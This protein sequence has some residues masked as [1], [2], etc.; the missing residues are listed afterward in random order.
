MFIVECIRGE[1]I[2]IFNRLLYSCIGMLPLKTHFYLNLVVRNEKASPLQPRQL[3][4]E[5]ELSSML[6]YCESFL[7]LARCE[8][9]PTPVVVASALFFLSLSPTPPPPSLL[10]PP[11]PPPP[12][13]SSVPPRCPPP[14]SQSPSSLHLQSACVVSAAGRCGRADLASVGV[15][16]RVCGRWRLL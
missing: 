5:H 1:K 10:P 4:R 7:T 11:L 2:S 16:V 14:F 15:L 3:S 6:L 12:P 13:P 8:K 9:F